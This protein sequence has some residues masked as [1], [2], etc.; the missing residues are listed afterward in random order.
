LETQKLSELKF[1]TLWQKALTYPS[2]RALVRILRVA[3]AAGLSAFLASLI[4]Q[5]QAEPSI[6]G[7][8]LVAILLIFLDE[9]L[10]N[11]KV[12]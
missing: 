4:P 10:R 2:F 8:P 5:L 12:Y 9:Y 7:I 3:A 1:E 11:K 6:G